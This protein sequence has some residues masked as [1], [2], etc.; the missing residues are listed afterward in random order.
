[1]LALRELALRRTA[2]HV[3]ADV[4]DYRR[5]HAIQ[6]AWPVNERLLVCVRPN[7]ESD[8]L[9]RAA[10]RLAA[11]LKAEW[12]VAY[13]ESDSQPPLSAGER[14][15]PARAPPPAR[16]PRGPT[17]RRPGGPAPAT[18]PPAAPPAPRNASRTVIGKPAHWAWRDRLRG[19]LLDDIVRGS[20]GIEVQV[21]PGGRRRRRGRRRSRARRGA[22][23]GPTSGPWPPCSSARSSA[24]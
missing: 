22:T 11:R 8:R 15:G 18:P 4:R 7:P 21:I 24:G 9:V 16:P 19:S 2:E 23:R 6:A 13:V 3:D 14:R 1:L 17:A 10:R 12:I 20:Q 5:D